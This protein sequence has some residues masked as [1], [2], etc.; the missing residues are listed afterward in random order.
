VLARRGIGDRIAKELGTGARIL[1]EDR[2][3]R[4]LVSV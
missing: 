3:S 4:G 2:L 1:E